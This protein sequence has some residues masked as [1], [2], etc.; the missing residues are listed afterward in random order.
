[1][2]PSPMPSLTY[3]TTD[4]TTLL[5]AISVDSGG[6]ARMQDL[7][8]PRSRPIRSLVGLPD[9]VLGALPWVTAGD[10]LDADGGAGGL[11]IVRSDILGGLIRVGMMGPIRASRRDPAPASRQCSRRFRAPRRRVPAPSFRERDSSPSARAPARR[12][13]GARRA[14]APGPRRTPQPRPCAPFPRSSA[15]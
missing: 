9:G 5:T 8:V 7:L 6:P 2:I 12:R 10:G 13:A 3:P 11:A 4:G 1:M 15:P 14:W